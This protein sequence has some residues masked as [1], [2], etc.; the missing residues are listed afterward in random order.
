M[1]DNNDLD[2]LL[3]KFKELGAIKIIA[4][5]L[6][7]NDNS[8]NQVYFGPSFDALSLLPTGKIET[9]GKGKMPTFKAPIRFNWLNELNIPYEAPYAQLI[10]YPKYPEVRF[11]GFLRGC[12]DSPS[13][14]NV[15][16][17][18][19]ILL[20]GITS[21]KIVYGK[22]VS[23]NHQIAK[24]YSTEKELVNLGVFSQLYPI[25]GQNED[26][27]ITLLDKLKEIHQ[28]SW[29]QSKRMHTDGEIRPYRAINGI[30][31]TLESEF[32]IT[33]NGYTAPDFL[34]WEMKSY[35]VHKFGK[36]LTK[37]LSLFTPEPDSGEYKDHNL[38]FFMEKYGYLD[39]HGNLRFNGAHK[40]GEIQ[41]KTGLVVTIDG[42]DYE[43]KKITKDSGGIILVNKDGEIA[44]RWSFAH[45]LEHWCKKHTRAVYVPG[46]RK[47]INDHPHY[48]YSNQIHICKDTDFEKFL[49]AFSKGHI[50]YD[51][52]PRIRKNGNEK[53]R[54]MFRTKTIH[55]PSLYETHEIVDTLKIR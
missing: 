38:R 15:R 24:D 29:I 26:S 33:P 30:G 52:A 5:E 54:S 1:F 50:Y 53:K 51:P 40:H 11:S 6:S 10:L 47:S 12:K 42:F 41:K 4:K 16:E 32:G 20:L 31:Y 17:E 2:I 3:K 44:A 7:E 49:S 45:L 13:N 23:R 34:G 37:V 22:V 27:E 36:V 21:E 19:R 14:M 9:D 35:T 8:K 25:E 48:H 46:I 55:L 43:S 28:K 18:G 39:D